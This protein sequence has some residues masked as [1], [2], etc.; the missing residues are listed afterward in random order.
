MIA[1][2]SCFTVHGSRSEPMMDIVTARSNGHPEHYLQKFSID[3]NTREVIL[4][5]LSMLGI[6]H[7]SI[8]PDLDRLGFDLQAEVGRMGNSGSD[9]QTPLS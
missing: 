4:A 8:F 7:A 2:R 9:I 6:M 3:S 1:Q 5:E